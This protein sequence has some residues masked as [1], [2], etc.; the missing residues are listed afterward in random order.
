MILLTEKAGHAVLSEGKN[1]Q[2]PKI[3]INNIGCD[4]AFGSV[5]K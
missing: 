5:E 2:Y 3:G 4:T 1:G